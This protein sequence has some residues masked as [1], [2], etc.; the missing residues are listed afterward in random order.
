MALIS[1]LNVCRLSDSEDN[2]QSW[3]DEI[4][5]N[6]IDGEFVSKDMFVENAMKLEIIQH[7]LKKKD[8]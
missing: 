5:R 1:I 3:I 2:I 8:I 4:M 7:C 6:A